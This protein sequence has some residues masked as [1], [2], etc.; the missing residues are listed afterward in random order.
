MIYVYCASGLRAAAPFFV[1]DGI[2]GWNVSM[3]DGSW[4]QWSSYASTATA[5]K[6]ARLADRRQHGGHHHQPHLWRHPTAGTSVVLDPVS[7]A[8]YSAVTDRRANQILNED[9]AYFTGGRFLCA[10]RW[11][12]WRRAPAVVSQIV[13]TLT[14]HE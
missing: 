10:G 1:L 5:N 9:K 11:R 14:F 2:L 12:W 8:M 4:N 13:L 7:N 6:V 3:Y